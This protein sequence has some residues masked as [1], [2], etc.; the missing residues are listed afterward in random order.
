MHRLIGRKVALG[1]ATIAALQLLAKSLDL[2]A[3]IVLARLL[4]PADFGLVAIATAILLIANS[5]TELPV[6]DVLVQRPSI[7]KADVDTAF[8]LN[9]LRGGLVAS[10]IM[11]LA[12]PVASFYS[13]DRLIPILLLLALA[14]LAQS[15]NSPALVHFLRRVEYGPS[16]R[17]MLIGKICGVCCSVILA[18]T[19]GSY[20]ALIGGLILAPAMTA[21]CTYFMAPYRP[22]LRLKGSRSILGFAGWVTVSRII[23]TLSMQADRIFVGRILGKAPLGYY[24]MGS[25]IA[26]LATYA[27]AGPVLQPIFSGF[28]RIKGDPERLRR[29]YLKSQQALLMVV[30][31][32]GVG[33][34]AV[35]NHL[36]P[37]LLGAEWT[38]VIPVIWWL[39]PVVALQMLS[40]PVQAVAM[41]LAQ[42][43]A[44]AMREALGLIIRLP[45]TL[46]AAWYGGLVGAAVARSLTGVIIILLNLMIARNLVDISVHRQILNGW[47]SLLSALVMAGV[48]LLPNLAFSLNHAST[49]EAGLVLVFQVLMGGVTY[50]GMHF[51]LWKLCGE[52]DGSE[53]FL[54]DFIRERITGKVNRVDV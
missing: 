9:L 13:D 10:V 14:P 50:V 15:L 36:I 5:V 8:T 19:T 34:A 17:S 1:T 33:L 52:P 30:L 40:V 45:V 16:A 23:W 53:K 43:R 27:V 20:W 12:W 18:L 4:T 24:T 54:I 38:S 47:R 7:D 26:S 32:F 11:L 37:L 28:S 48:V 21:V 39:A 6:I 44:L 42:P 41:A 22:R 29:A 25:D 51:G 35:A 31:P 3:L 2:I 46:V 49:W